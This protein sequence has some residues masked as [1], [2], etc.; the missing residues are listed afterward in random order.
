[1]GHTNNNRMTISRITKLLL[2]HSLVRSITSHTWRYGAAL[3]ATVLLVLMPQHA[4]AQFNTD[5]LMVSGRSAL[6]Y[7]DYV[8]SIQYFNQVL[9]A[10]PYLYEPWFFRGLAK[11]YLDDFG[12]AESDVTHAIGLNPYIYNMYELRGLC[13]IRQKNYAQ[14][15]ADYDAA[16]RLN[17]QNQS[18]WYNRALCRVEDKDYKR[19]QLDL[20][21]VIVKWKKFAPAYSLKA[22]V[23]LAQ[24][25]TTQADQ[26]LDRSLEVDPFDADAWNTRAMISLSRSKWR[27]ADTYLSKSI[28]LKPKNV[29][30]YVNRALARYN[31]NN[32]RGAMA[33]YDT[34]LD[35]DP[36]NFLAH[37]NRGL[38]RMQLGDD[39]RAITDF[40]YV[41]R[42]EPENVLAIYNR[43]ILLD[44]TGN[45]RAA[46]RDYTRM[47]N[48]YPNFWTGLSARANCYRR[49]GM[50]AKAEMDEF[51]IMKAQM[52]KH[53]GIQPRW[54][55]SKC[56]QMR[57]R[58]EIDPNKYNQIVV[59]DE[60]NAEHEYKSEYRGRVQNRATGLDA[61]PMYHLSFAPM[62]G[63]V[64]TYHAFAQKVEAFNAAHPQPRL[65]VVCGTA[66]MDEAASRRLLQRVD[67]LTAVVGTARGE[68]K[69]AAA[70]V[71]RAVAETVAQN[72]E[73]AISD[74]EACLGIDSTSVVALW[75][76]AYCQTMMPEFDNKT[77]N[78]K[79]D[80]TAASL[81]SARIVSCLD[82]AIQAD[83]DNQYLYYNRGCAYM[84]ERDYIH[85]IDDF[86]RAINIDHSLAE[87]YYNRGLARVQNGLKSEGIAD[88]S[89]AGEL[90]LY[91]AYSVI[92]KISNSKK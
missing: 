65:Y 91:K 71:Q 53:L 74:L 70:L 55:N 21:T 54:N 56:K 77:R 61:Q 28:H 59:A 15:I 85:A 36:D 3:V 27:D 30:N 9:T 52:D 5:R 35:L 4:S 68:Q 24:K 92:K 10:K 12:G 82:L 89:K 2:H 25:D 38:L 51:R 11:F 75:Q 73:G 64:H 31:V 26:W 83:K 81:K 87:A 44:K 46:I 78:A 49:L 42:M 67:S 19:A 39:N 80:A 17:P 22:Q 90:G 23:C 45:L 29:G 41:I 14:A 72:Y 32:L 7:E 69:L 33:D 40:D 34:A 62:V 1:M 8:L 50:T 63:D 76:R 16:I 86:T 47:I 58:S 18:A 48:E 6:Y 84:A 60:N 88:L 37:Y 66:P 20:D 13:R 57:R 43:A 79:G